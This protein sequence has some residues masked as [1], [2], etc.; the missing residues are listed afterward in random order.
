MKY[1]INCGNKLN[2]KDYFCTKCGSKTNK[3]SSK[4]ILMLGIFLVL[5]FSFILGIISWKSLSEILRI[6]FFGFECI[7]FFGLSFILKK[8]ENK[9]YRLYQL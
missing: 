6:S 4:P 7:L 8:T 3:Q 1:C 2:E 5:F 9:L